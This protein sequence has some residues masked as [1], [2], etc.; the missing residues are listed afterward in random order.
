VKRIFDYI[1]EIPKF[2]K[3]HSNEYIGQFLRYLGNPEAGKK[4]IHVAGTNGKGTV[5]SYMKA[6]LLALGKE[7]GCFTSP[8]LVY[9]NERININGQDISDKEFAASFHYVKSVVEEMEKA[10]LSHP[11]YFEFLFG[12]ALVAFQKRNLTYLILETGIGGRLD[13]TNVISHPILTVITSIGLDHQEI[14][15]ETLEEI[16]SEKAGIIKAGTPLVYDANNVI[17]AKV[18]HNTAL[19]KGSTYCE[20][21][22]DCYEVC[23][24]AEKSIAFFMRDS[25][26]E[27]TI[28]RTR[29]QG[30]WQVANAAIALEAMRILEMMGEVDKCLHTW[31]QAMQEAL[32]QGRMQQIETGIVLDG[33]HN[34]SAIQQ[35]V[36]SVSLQDTKGL[37]ILFAVM[38]DKPYE[39][40]I[41]CLCETL[42]L[43][44]V[45][46]T[47]LQDMR[48]VK[49]DTLEEVFA[50]YT[51][52]PIDKVSNVQEAWKRI[53]KIDKT[54]TTVYC[55]GSLYLIGDILKLKKET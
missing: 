30:I 20:V 47:T 41:Q 46:V 4:V 52:A 27:R 29:G 44:R 14:L 6:M 34:L 1:E 19:E 31:Q 33:G 13:A 49:A 32:W 12:M 45:L 26:Y 24:I 28:W 7:V 17:S 16:A 10:G 54:N 11:S 9:L 48:S 25:Y 3:K 53:E 15:G 50:K 39:D 55:L 37:I 51:K 23:E 22:T 21:S 5:C 36:K 8:H 35:F 40:M 42:D 2:T 18:I 38:K 43:K